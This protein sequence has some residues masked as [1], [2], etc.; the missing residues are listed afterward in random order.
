MPGSVRL[1][2]FRLA[3]LAACGLAYA[4]S[5]FLITLPGRVS[6]AGVAALI[7]S[8][9]AIVWMISK[10]LVEP[11]MGLPRV[12]DVKVLDSSTVCYPTALSIRQ[13]V[14]PLCGPVFTTIFWLPFLI[15][16]LSCRDYAT[17][18]RLLFIFLAVPG[19][20]RRGRSFRRSRRCRSSCRYGSSRTAVSFG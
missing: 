1:S 15:V 18:S 16:A 6:E 13:L 3:A 10:W 17:F 5:L 2:G 20:T 8:G 11:W 9:C 19:G 4:I 7:A 14:Y 12:E